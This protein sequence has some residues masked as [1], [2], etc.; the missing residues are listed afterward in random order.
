EHGNSSKPQVARLERGWT[1]DDVAVRLHQMSSELGEPPPGVD[2]NQVSKWE[3]GVRKPGRFYRPRLCLIFEARPEHLGFRPTP[4]LL[5]DIADLTR[6]RARRHQTAPGVGLGQLANAD[7]AESPPSL[8]DRERLA[9]TLRYLWPVDAPL[10]DSLEAVADDFA[11]RCER[12]SPASLLP[13]LRRHH[14]VLQELMS[15]SQP[16]ALEDRLRAIG[17]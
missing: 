15:R 6:M 1:E 11:A 4:R 17:G 8:V 10:V 14:G 13:E 9:D 3:R 16:P 5:Q 12:E 2:G 7:P